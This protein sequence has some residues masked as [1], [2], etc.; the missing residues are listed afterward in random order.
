MRPTPSTQNNYSTDEKVDLISGRFTEIMQIL[1]LDLNNSSLRNTPR[2]VAQMYVREI[3][4]GLDA[5]TFPRVTVIENDMCYDQMIVVRDIAVLSTCETNLSRSKERP[6]SPT[7]PRAGGSL[8][9]LKLNRIVKFFSRRPQ[10][11]E[12]LMRTAVRSSHRDLDRAATL[13]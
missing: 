12:R 10:V 11:Q 3:F 4:A 5:R 6:T 1:G 13:P 9:Y 8:G 2:R 7:F